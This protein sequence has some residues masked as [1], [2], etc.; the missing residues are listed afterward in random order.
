[1]LRKENQGEFEGAVVKI[2]NNKLD[3]VFE[4]FF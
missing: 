1:M 3:E 4:T 2:V